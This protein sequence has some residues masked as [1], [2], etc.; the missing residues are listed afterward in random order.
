MSFISRYVVFVILDFYGRTKRRCAIVRNNKTYLLEN[1]Q[2][3]DELIALLLSNNCITTEQRHFIQ[4]QR[5]MRDKNEKLL[6]I[7][8]SFDRKDFPNVVRCLR[9]TNQLTVAKITEIGGGLKQK[10]YLKTFLL[11][12]FITS[13]FA[14]RF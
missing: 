2:L 13:Y 1:I 10:L 7:M 3:N 5:S 12:I 8:A 4:L 11:Q 6:H 9:R 14:N